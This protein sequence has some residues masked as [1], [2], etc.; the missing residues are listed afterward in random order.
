LP[1][2]ANLNASLGNLQVKSP[3]K[4]YKELEQRPE[5]PEYQVQKKF[6]EN[7]NSKFKTW[8]SSDIQDRSEDLANSIFDI[9]ENTHP[10]I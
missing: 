6:L 9:I 1:I 10:N 2:S 3:Y 7:Y 5:Y 4:K 8:N